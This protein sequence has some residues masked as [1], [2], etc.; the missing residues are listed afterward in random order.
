MAKKKQQRLSLLHLPKGAIGDIAEL[1]ENRE[2]VPRV[3]QAC[4]A[5]KP[6]ASIAS[7]SLAVASKT[8]LEALVVSE[9]AMALWNLK[10]LQRNLEVDGKRLIQEVTTALQVQATSEWKAEYSEEWEKTSGILADALQAITDD[11][12]LMISA[13]A[14]NLA[15]THPDLFIGCRVIT[16]V[17]PVFD[18]AGNKIVETVITH[19][20]AINCVDEAQERRLMTF[21]LDQKD[22]TALRKQ[23]ERAD[24]KSK[25]VLE[26]L[27]HLNPV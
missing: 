21:A 10:N 26:A 22:L 17:R 25:V 2:H 19:T 12:P 7:L 15:Y 3:V 18:T 14:T 5:E 6:A 11:H 23:C 20:L 8:S 16:D 1:I 27:K 13:K 9:I 24:R 4:S